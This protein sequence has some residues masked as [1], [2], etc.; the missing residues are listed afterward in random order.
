[1]PDPTTHLLDLTRTLLDRRGGPP[2]LWPRAAATLT[3]QALE[4]CLTRLWQRRAPGLEEAS[5]RAQL[6]CLPEFLHGTDGD[7][8]ADLA[9]RTALAWGELSSACHAGDYEM[10]VDRHTVERSLRTVAELGAHPAL[11]P[12][13][14]DDPGGITS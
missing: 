11:G 6:A 14:T 13:S 3:R 10:A 7:D 12:G 5:M 9:A 1:M 2:G 8:T 4:H